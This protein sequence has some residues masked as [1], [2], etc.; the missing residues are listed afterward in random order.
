MRGEEIFLHSEIFNPAVE[1][2]P[3]HDTRLKLRYDAARVKFT[4]YGVFH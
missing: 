4:L 3:T 1:V 2:P